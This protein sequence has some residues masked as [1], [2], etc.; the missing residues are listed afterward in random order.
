MSQPSARRGRGRPPIGP[1]FEFNLEPE[2]YAELKRRAE[3]RGRPIAE[4][5]RE[6]IARRLAEPDDAPYQERLI[7]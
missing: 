2:A 1:R 5:V 3:R 4:L 6:A 7:A